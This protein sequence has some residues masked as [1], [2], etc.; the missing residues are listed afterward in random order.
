MVR[1]DHVGKVL[2][3]GF[4]DTTGHL[5]PVGLLRGIPSHDYQYSLS[6]SDLYGISVPGLGRSVRRVPRCSRLPLIERLQMLHGGVTLSKGM[7]QERG[8][9]WTS[10]VFVTG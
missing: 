5:R 10:S 4:L 3:A 7:R 9:T 8:M 6:N 1:P 2:Q